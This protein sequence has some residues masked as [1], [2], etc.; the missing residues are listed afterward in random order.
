MASDCALTAVQIIRDAVRGMTYLKPGCC[1][2]SQEGTNIPPGPARVSTHLKSP[3]APPRD[4]VAPPNTRNPSRAP[5]KVHVA[6][7]LT[8]RSGPNRALRFAR[9]HS[10]YQNTGSPLPSK[11]GPDRPFPRTCPVR[12]CL[13]VQVAIP[14]TKSS[15]SV[16]TPSQGLSNNQ[17]PAQHPDSSALRQP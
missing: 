5:P 9:T 2:W 11:R 15:T 14:N 10:A 17:R 3:L 4:Q 1:E 13:I 16:P 6:P 7:S 12:P 8:S